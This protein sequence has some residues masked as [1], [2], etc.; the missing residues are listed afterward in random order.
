MDVNSDMDAATR[1]RKFGL[2]DWMVNNI[3]RLNFV[4]DFEQYACSPPETEGF[5]TEFKEGQENFQI[6]EAYCPLAEPKSTQD[7]N[8]K[9]LNLPKVSPEDQS[10]KLISSHNLSPTLH[11]SL[12]ESLKNEEFFS[13]PDSTP[14]STPQPS[15]VVRRKMSNPSDTVITN[16]G[17]WFYLGKLSKL[18]NNLKEYGS[19][20]KNKENRDRTEGQSSL[21]KV[22]PKEPILESKNNGIKLM[23]SNF[24]LNAVSPTS[25]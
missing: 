24:D 22:K 15:P 13:S 17:R 9:N 21:N 4:T 10:S 3:E 5:L 16:P 19:D 18:Q 6:S 1:Q 23:I 11:N 12:L 25:W 8:L 7:I 20:S 2:P 14:C